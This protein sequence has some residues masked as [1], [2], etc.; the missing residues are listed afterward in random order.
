MFLSHVDRYQAVA[1]DV[2]GV[3]D[4]ILMGRQSGQSLQC[5]YIYPPSTPRG[6]YHFIAI[7]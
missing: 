3:F 1:G 5:L 7:I 6:S 4:D 2:N